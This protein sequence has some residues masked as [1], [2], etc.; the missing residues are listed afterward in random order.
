MLGGGETSVQK[1]GPQKSEPGCADLVILPV[2][3]IFCS[4]VRTFVWSRIVPA[5]LEGVHPAPVLVNRVHEMHGG[6]MNGVGGGED[7]REK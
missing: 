6:R 2:S 3:A 5:Y 4:P 1:T 7:E